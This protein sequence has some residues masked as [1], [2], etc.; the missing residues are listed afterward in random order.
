MFFGRLIGFT[1]ISSEG[2]SL[3]NISDS[4]Y[5][6]LTTVRKVIPGFSSLSF[7]TAG[8][9]QEIGAP[10][11]TFRNLFTGFVMAAHMG[12]FFAAR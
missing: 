8:V 6:I 3:A 1:E 4:G 10:D 11:Q 7:F 2:F 12:G 5:G 9:L